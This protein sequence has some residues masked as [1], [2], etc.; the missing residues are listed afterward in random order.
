MGTMNKVFTSEQT[1]I[2]EIIGPD[3]DSAEF[4][5][6]ENERRAHWVVF[7][8][9]GEEG[10]EYLVVMADLGYGFVEAG[11]VSVAE[12]GELGVT[13]VE[14]FHGRGKPMS[15]FSGRVT[16]RGLDAVR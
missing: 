15:A 3:G 10:L 4:Y 1:Q 16:L 8:G 6:F 14:E 13:A 9:G 2:L 5:V 7:G 12:L 11:T